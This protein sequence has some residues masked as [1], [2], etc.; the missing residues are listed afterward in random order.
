MINN[1][2]SKECRLF[3]MEQAAFLLSESEFGRGFGIFLLTEYTKNITINLSF[4]GIVKIGGIRG[5]IIIGYH[6]I[7]C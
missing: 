5:F 6:S 4:R 7:T 3:C 2:I 1:D